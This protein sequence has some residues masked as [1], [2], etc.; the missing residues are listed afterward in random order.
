MPSNWA[1]LMSFIQSFLS[2]PRLQILLLSALHVRVMNEK[3]Q[4]SGGSRLCTV[5][6]DAASVKAC[7]SHI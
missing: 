6:C 5:F 3:S 2:I 4:I 1:G 7:I